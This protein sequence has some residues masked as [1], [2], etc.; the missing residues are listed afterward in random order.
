MKQKYVYEIEEKTVKAAEAEW[1]SLP[2]PKSSNNI[3]TH[4]LNIAEEYK[5]AEVTPIYI[6]DPGLNYMYVSFREKYFVTIH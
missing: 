1:E 4:L 6:F 5:K 3:Y 2:E